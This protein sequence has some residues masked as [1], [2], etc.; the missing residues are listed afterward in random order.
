MPDEVR[1][2]L[3]PGIRKVTCIPSDLGEV[4]DAHAHW[5]SQSAQS[6]PKSLTV[7]SKAGKAFGSS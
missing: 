7:P 1:P 6:S 4:G 2:N 3:T 5:Q